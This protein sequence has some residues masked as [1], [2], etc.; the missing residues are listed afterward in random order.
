MKI[1]IVCTSR[2]EYDLVEDFILYHSAIVGFEH[3][4]LVDNGS[5]HPDIPDLLERF[6]TWGVEVIEAPERTGGAW[7]NVLMTKIIHQIKDQCDY[8]VPIDTDEF[9]VCYD[10]VLAKKP[11]SKERIL[12]QFQLLSDEAS[13]IKFPLTFNSIVNPEDASYQRGV[14]KRPAQDI[15]HFEPVYNYRLKWGAKSFFKAQTFDWVNEGNHHGNVTSG[16]VALSG[17]GLFHFHYTGAKRLFE[18]ASQ[19]VD[20]STLIDRQLP[21]EEQLTLCEQPYEGVN[22]QRREEYHQFLLRRWVVEKFVTQHYT[23]PSLKTLNQL[24]QLRT[25]Q[26]IADHI[27]Q[28]EVP[29]VASSQG[30]VDPEERDRLIY[31]DSPLNEHHPQFS[32]VFQSSYVS[33]VLT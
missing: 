14:Y 18:R 7:Q 20:A 5:D 29:P 24:T 8:V 19:M 32:S 25:W 22:R 10:D 26:V 30:D 2:N 17:L 21:L 16:E 33:D 27:R 6:R 13:L 9:L 4:V 11:F 1:K 15:K 28:M 3:L 23:L 31:D 12:K